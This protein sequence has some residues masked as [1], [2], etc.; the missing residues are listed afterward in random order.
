MFSGIYGTARHLS[1]SDPLAFGAK[2]LIEVFGPICPNKEIAMCSD[3]DFGTLVDHSNTHAFHS[4][5][6]LVIQTCSKLNRP[7]AIFSP[8]DLLSRRPNPI[9]QI[10]W[11]TSL[12]GRHESHSSSDASPS[13]S[14]SCSLLTIT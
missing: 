6:F 9:L 2:T 11:K 13:S 7:S 8:I 10:G 3:Y 12:E 4:S 14:P 5:A 1:M